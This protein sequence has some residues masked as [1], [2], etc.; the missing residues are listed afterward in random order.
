MLVTGS[1]D[2]KVKVWDLRSGKAVQTFREHE[3]IINAAQL[4]PDSKWVASGGEDGALKIW[5]IA[6]GKVL[7]NFYLPSQAVTCI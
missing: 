6:S 7:N 3:G 2:T 1:D 4:S 5:E